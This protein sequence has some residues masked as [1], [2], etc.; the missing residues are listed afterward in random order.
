VTTVFFTIGIVFKKTIAEKVDKI[1]K[2][3]EKK[4]NVAFL[5]PKTDAQIGFEERIQENELKGKD[6]KIDFL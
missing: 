1:H 5:Y 3:V 6:T 2:I 4:E